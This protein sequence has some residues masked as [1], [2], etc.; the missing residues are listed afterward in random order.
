MISEESKKEPLLGVIRIDYDIALCSQNK[1][2]FKHWA[3][4][5]KIKKESANAALIGY[6]RGKKI[7]VG[8]IDYPLIVDAIVY[9]KTRMDRHNIS[10]AL[11]W[12]LDILFARRP[13]KVGDKIS[14]Y[15]PGILTPDDSDKYLIQ[16]SVSQVN[17]SKYKNKEY[18]ELFVYSSKN[19]TDFEK[20]VLRNS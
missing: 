1:L 18:L 5:S 9:R 12:T 2:E 10:G 20:R 6:Q 19:L 17:D 7:S 11:K 4:Q 15:Q 3:T 8:Q 14:F 16:R 13:V